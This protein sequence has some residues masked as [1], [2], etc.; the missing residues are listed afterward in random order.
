MFGHKAQECKK[1]RSQPKKN[2]PNN[3]GRKS[4]EVWKKRENHNDK[5][6]RPNSGRKCLIQKWIVKAPR[7]NMSEVAKD[8]HE[9]SKKKLLLEYPKDSQNKVEE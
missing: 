7:P 6:Q 2:D 9:D 5:T 1:S 3:S 8:I 4:N